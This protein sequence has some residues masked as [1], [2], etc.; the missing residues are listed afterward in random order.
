MTN[1]F[2]SVLDDELNLLKRD[3]STQIKA[4]KYDD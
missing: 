2:M 3:Q 4:D 1:G